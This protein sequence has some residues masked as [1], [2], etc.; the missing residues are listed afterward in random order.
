LYLERGLSP[1]ALANLEGDG[2]VRTELLAIGRG[3]AHRRAQREG[4]QVT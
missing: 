2:T 4:E 1:R 3:T